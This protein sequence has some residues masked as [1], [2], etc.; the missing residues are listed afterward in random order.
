MVKSKR[1]FFK[2]YD[3]DHRYGQVQAR[4]M[5]RSDVFPEESIMEAETVSHFSLHS[6]HR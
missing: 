2:P 4:R 6:L 3:L 5:T 1:A